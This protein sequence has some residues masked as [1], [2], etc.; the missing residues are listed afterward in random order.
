M[1]DTG[2]ALA[3]ILIT[4]WPSAGQV[5]EPA[6]TLLTCRAAADAALVGRGNPLYIPE[7]EQAASARCIPATPEQAGFVSGWDCIDGY[8]C[9]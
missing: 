4:V 2:T 9:R 8:N 7:G 3:A 5:A 1:T 6:T